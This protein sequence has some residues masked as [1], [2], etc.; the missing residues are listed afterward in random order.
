M[1]PEIRSIE[2]QRAEF[3]RWGSPDL[4]TVAPLIHL[5]TQVA[6]RLIQTGSR[7]AVTATGTPLHFSPTFSGTPVIICQ[8]RG[9]TGT[10]Y[11]A[12]MKTVHRSGGTIRLV[13]AG[14]KV[15][16]YLAWDPAR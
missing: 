6:K 4:G 5:G 8:P 15:V 7:A 14:T 10:F 3:C 12:G 1:S 11:S 13:V 16:D 2:S 9:F